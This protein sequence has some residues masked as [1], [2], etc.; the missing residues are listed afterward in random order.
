MRP[1]NKQVNIEAL[2]LTNEFA[3]LKRVFFFLTGH[4]HRRYIVI[5]RRRGQTTSTTKLF[6]QRSGLW[7]SV[8]F[9]CVAALPS[10]SII[11]TQISR[12]G[13]E[14]F[15]WK[16]EQGV[17][18]LPRRGGVVSLLFFMTVEGRFGTVFFFFFLFC[19]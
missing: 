12:G 11:P 16:G 19:G 7:R 2:P 18:S 15:K 8:A 9:V 10:R 14:I 5:E 1:Q 4:M 3:H 17:E 6:P 13:H